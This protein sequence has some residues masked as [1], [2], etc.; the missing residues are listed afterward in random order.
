MPTVVRRGLITVHPATVQSL[1][2]YLD[3]WL[4]ARASLRSSTRLA[5]QIHITRFLTPTTGHVPLR[6]LTVEDVED[7][8]RRILAGEFGIVSVSTLHRIHAT[9][10]SALNAA[11]RRG[12]IG[13]NPAALVELPRRE[14]AEMTVWTTGEAHRFL[15]H[16]VDDPRYL[17][18]RLLLLTGMR[19]G[20][21]LGLQWRD[22]DRSSSAL[23]IHRQLTLVAGQQALGEPK[24]ARG[25][26]TIHLDGDTATLLQNHHAEF[27][28][29]GEQPI[30]HDQDG[31]PLDPAA[32]SRHFTVLTKEL[33]LP[34]IRLH[35]LR[36]TSASIGLEAGE[37]LTQVSRR[38]GH[39]TVAIT[40]DIYTHVSSEAAQL[41]AETLAARIGSQLR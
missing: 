34:V 31:S 25:H 19:R 38:L 39:S 35:D 36:H 21:A 7:A 23:H 13:S 9:L 18:Y 22:W 41:A 32:V 28:G 10:M 26:R 6:E 5:Y 17:L 16:A 33:G 20:E 1:S 29:T 30:F 15:T 37:P 11:V 8:Y 24:S 3:A 40:G 27:G 2:S 4:A 14:R 12:F